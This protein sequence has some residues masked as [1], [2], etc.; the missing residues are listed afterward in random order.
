M[1]TKSIRYMHYTN[2]LNS[3]AIYD[4]VKYLDEK[5]ACMRISYFQENCEINVIFKLQ[6]VTK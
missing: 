2:G 5:N 6:N 3:I 1:K 4:T